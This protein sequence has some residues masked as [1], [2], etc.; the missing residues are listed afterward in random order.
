MAKQLDSNPPNGTSNIIVNSFTPGYC[1]SGL[2]E[3]VHGITG[4]ALW[5]LSKATARTTEVG[6][7]TL[8]AAIAQGDKSHGKYLNDGHIDEYEPFREYLSSC[9]FQA[10]A[11]PCLLSSDQHCLHS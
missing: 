9:N 4:F 1:T 2:I 6:G 10:V 7:R 5:L 11:D 3:N 8:V